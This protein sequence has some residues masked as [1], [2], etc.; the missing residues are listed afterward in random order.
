MTRNDIATI[1]AG[2]ELTDAQV[3]ALLD[4]NS[5]DITKALSRQKD[6]L[7]AANEALKKAQET[8]A[9]LEAGKA[10]AA[11]L[12]KQIDQYKRA[13]DGRAAAEKQASEEAELLRRMDAALDGR[14]FVHEKLRD[15]V[16]GEFRAALADEANRGKSDREVFA[17]VTR[18]K[19]YFANQNPSAE[20]LPPPGAPDLER[21]TGKEAFRA[22]PLQRQF[23]FARQNPERAREYLQD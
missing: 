23:L 10:D 5:A 14:G 22:M 20:K 2:L 21:V 19:G 8:I 7:T 13:E 15:I 9:A 12:Q 17:A 16:A 4:A 11:A 6:G 18:D 3:K 1:L